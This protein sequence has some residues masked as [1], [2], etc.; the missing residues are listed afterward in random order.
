MA[1]MRQMADERAMA[2]YL[3]LA[4]LF[5]FLLVLAAIDVALIQLRLLPGHS[6][7]SWLRAHFVT[8]GVLA[9]AAFAVITAAS[10]RAS[11]GGTAWRWPTWLAL[12]AGLLLLLI[13]LPSINA[14][15]LI[16]GGTLF[17]VAV[18]LLFWRLRAARP[19]LSLT[20]GDARPF[21]A[22]SLLYLLLGVFLGTGLWLGWGSVIGLA[23]PKEVHVH[24]NLWG[25]TSLFFA[26][27]F[28]DHYPHFAGRPLAWPRSLS[29]ILWLMV[30]G[31]LG[32]VAGPWLQINLITT[33][34]LVLHTVATIWLMA[35][36]LMPLRASRSSRRQPGLWHLFSAY[37][38]F[39]IPVVVAP[40]IVSNAE[41]IPVGQIE[42][43]GG[44]ILIYG[45]ILPIC[46]ALVPY[47]VQRALQPDAEA[48]LGGSWLSLIAIH[49]GAVLYW[50]GLFLYDYQGMLHGSAFLFWAVSLL[51]V[52][53]P[54]VQLVRRG[55][56]A[57][58]GPGE[59]L[60][61]IRAGDQPIPST[62][63]RRR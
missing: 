14:T 31:A 16:G 22:V 41:S 8:I 43:Q 7:L 27:F 48:R 2:P 5:L 54:L 40:L 20:V 45:W 42:Q 62:R 17:F 33:V 29:A 58:V 28:V 47:L 53:V 26:G 13:G 52:V 10:A 9:E 63:E 32:L 37:I 59:P 49:A 55:V 24:T 30:L 6:G 44:P 21:Y 60:M 3:L 34:G 57:V 56:E 35:N 39:F 15:L 12:H 46:Y 61:A 36:L 38:W 1:S 18:L 25:F 19:A 23:G 50:L 51:P 4:T 11:G